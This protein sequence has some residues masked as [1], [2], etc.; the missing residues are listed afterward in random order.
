MGDHHD[1]CPKS[2]LS[3]R[4]ICK[5]ISEFLESR[6][7]VGSSARRILGSLMMARAMARAA[8]RR[9]KARRFVV[10]A[11]LEANILV[12]TSK[13]WDR[14]RR[15]NELRDG[16]VAFGVRVGSRLKR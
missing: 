7:P 2:L 12:T 5:T 15:V 13:R 14:S 4:S 8:V 6:L 10:Q 3:R 9:R 1:V 16:D 11:A